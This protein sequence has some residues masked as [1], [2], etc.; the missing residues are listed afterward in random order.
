MKYVVHSKLI[1]E[2]IQ[3]A[4]SMQDTLK[5]EALGN[6]E[7]MT[8]INEAKQSAF[9]DTFG[10]DEYTWSDIRQIEIGKIKGKLFKLGPDQKPNNLE[11]LTEDISKGLRNS[12]PN[13]LSN[14]FE[15]VV[16]DLRNCAI[17]R[18]INGHSNNFYE[19]IFSI[20]KAGGFPCGWKGEYPSSGKIIAYF[21]EAD[22]SK[23][24]EQY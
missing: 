11:K 23:G 14:F 4:D 15:N 24:K 5:S 6:I 10:E 21:K 2:V 18:A 12:L 17:N 20:Y 13:S 22:I 9:N 16:V 1:E 7:I 19:Q 3:V 8:D